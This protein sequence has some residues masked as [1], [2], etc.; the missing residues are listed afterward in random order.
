MFGLMATGDQRVVP[1][2]RLI[3][4]RGQIPFPTADEIQLREPLSR[5]SVGEWDL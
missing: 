3:N 1:A 2:L 4:S 5:G